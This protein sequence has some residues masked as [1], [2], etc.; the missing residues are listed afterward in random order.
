MPRYNRVAVKFHTTDE[1]YIF[2]MRPHQHR[3]AVYPAARDEVLLDWLGKQPDLLSQHRAAELKKS[4]V[5]HWLA[6]GDNLRQDHRFI[7]AIGAIREALRLDSTPEALAKLKE[8]VTIQAQIDADFGAAQ[9]QASDGHHGEAI[10]LL[11][12]VL[13]LKPDHAGAH[14]KLGGLYANAGKR[15]EAVEHLKAVARYDPDDAYGFNMLGWLAFRDGDGEA[16][17]K[18]FRRADEIL[19]FSAEIN[20]RWGLALRLLERWPDAEARF[21]QV[22]AIDPNHAGGCQGLSDA[23]RRQGHPEEAVRF[24]RRAARLTDFENSDVLITLVEAYTAA[25]RAA[26]AQN[27][28]AQALDAARRNNPESA[29]QIQARL[30]KIS[31]RGG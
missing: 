7:A 15:A 17:V 29:A 26:D 28:A 10:R 2:P 25:G 19:P 12:N 4:L 14:G 8:V 27:A 20:Y 6:E 3:I 31:A 23:L 22:L 21:R 30:K 5:A 13:R 16:A 9:R 18:A 1:Q 11:E 24:A